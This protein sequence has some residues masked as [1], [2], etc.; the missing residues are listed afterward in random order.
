MNC[1]TCAAH[2]KPPRIREGMRVTIPEMEKV[3]LGKN[4]VGTVE[5]LGH[6]ETLRRFT[7]KVRW[8]SGHKDQWWPVNMLVPLP[9]EPAAR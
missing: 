3:W 1:L 4:L 2:R 5:Q 7:A 8:D 9:D 6:P